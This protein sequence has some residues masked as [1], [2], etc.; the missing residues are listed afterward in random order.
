MSRIRG[1][2]N[3]PNEHAYEDDSDYQGFCWVCGRPHKTHTEGFLITT[4]P[5]CRQEL[6]QSEIQFLNADY[7]LMGNAYL[8]CDNGRH[9]VV[10]PDDIISWQ[11][12]AS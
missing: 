8:R 10:R 2:S 4:C 12:G 3:H 5:K 7:L 1:L 11:R 9:E 6:S